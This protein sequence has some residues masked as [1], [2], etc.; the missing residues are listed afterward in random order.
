M[1]F[2]YN[3]CVKLIWAAGLFVYYQTS[4]GSHMIYRPCHWYIFSICCVFHGTDHKI[5][6]KGSHAAHGPPV[7]HT[8]SRQRTNHNFIIRFNEHVRY[9]KNKYHEAKINSTVSIFHTWKRMHYTH[10]L[11]V[12]Y[13]VT[14][15]PPLV[16]W[17]TLSNSEQ[18]GFGIIDSKFSPGPTYNI[19]KSADSSLR[20]V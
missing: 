19:F 15:T 17:G 10:Q 1:L 3:R 2:N 4:R 8:C 18:N 20:R 14:L 12:I 13:D 7:W 6:C 11:N 9:V 5:T 16:G